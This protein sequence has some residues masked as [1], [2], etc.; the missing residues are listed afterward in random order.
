MVSLI[1][2]SSTKGDDLGSGKLSSK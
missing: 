2:S 1:Q